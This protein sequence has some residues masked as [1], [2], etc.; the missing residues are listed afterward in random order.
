M[1]NI[2]SNLLYGILRIFAFLPLPLLFFFS[3]VFLYPI[4]YYVVGY[5]LKVVRANLKN[6]FPD[7]T[8]LELRKIEREFYHHFCDTFEETVRVL[9]MSERE[10]RKRM[11]F[12]NPTLLTDFAK[13]GQGVLLVLGHYG[14]WEYLPFLFLDMLES[15]NQV[16]YSIYRPL[17]SAAFNHLYIKIRTHFGGPVITKTEAYRAIIRLRREGKAGVFGLVSDQSPSKSNLHY[18]TNFLNQETAILTGPERMA[19]Q[20]GFAVVFVDVEKTSRGHYQATY[21]LITDNPKDTAENEITEKY[22]R[23]MEKTILREPSYWLW[24]HKRWKHKRQQESEIKR[25]LIA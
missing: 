15:G 13:Q 19:K 12:T 7:K 20:T 11:V 8:N 24:T 18:W 17:K 9:G 16:G 22:A 21:N 4:V 6:S 14:N 3:D 10:A 23:L 25:E 1:K 2:S 5:R